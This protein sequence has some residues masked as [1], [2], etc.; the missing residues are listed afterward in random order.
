M[1]R[2]V[3]GL[4]VSWEHW[5]AN[6]RPRA[7][8][9]KRGIGGERREKALRGRLQFA[10][11]ASR[12][13]LFMRQAFDLPRLSLCNRSSQFPPLSFD[14]LPLLPFQTIEKQDIVKKGRKDTKCRGRT[15]ER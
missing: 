12:F 10:S 14:F 9:E 8:K 4:G 1:S 5:E 15:N 2:R 11:L 3:N 13:A 7:R 6:E